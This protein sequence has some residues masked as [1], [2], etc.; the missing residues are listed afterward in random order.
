[1]EKERYPRYIA[2][3]AGE[4]VHDD[5]DLH[6]LIKTVTEERIAEG[7]KR[8]VIITKHDHADDHKGETV[9]V[10][11]P[12]EENFAE[13]VYALLLDI[14][15]QYEPLEGAGEECG[16]IPV[17]LWVRVKEALDLEGDQG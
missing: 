2:W 15:E 12:P 8:E 10:I 9:H 6:A 17:T 14:Y 7:R 16:T 4:Y 5:E 13:R 1:M 11:P 3:V